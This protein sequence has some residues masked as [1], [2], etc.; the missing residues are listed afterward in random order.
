VSHHDDV[1]AETPLLIDPAAPD[2]ASRIGFRVEYAF[3]IDGNASGVATIEVFG[4]NREEL[5]E[6]RR[7]RLR[8]FEQWKEFNDLLAQ[9]IRRVEA[10]DKLL[11]AELRERYER[12]LALLKEL[13]R[14]EAEYAM[15]MRA[16]FA[17]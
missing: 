7:D 15:M 3:A 13:I 11:A 4:L 6:V 16:A 14:D 12:S 8:E 5:V 17:E 9:E 1:Q 10:A 2:I